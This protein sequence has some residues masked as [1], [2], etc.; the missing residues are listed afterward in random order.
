[1][2]DDVLIER[3]TG[4]GLECS[5][6]REN[7]KCEDL[8]E[9]QLVSQETF[10]R[11]E[12]ITH[13]KTLTKEIDHN[14]NKSGKFIHLGSVEEN[15]YN[16]KSDKK[17]FSQNSVVVKHKKVYAGKKV[18]KCNEC[19]KTFTHSSSLTVHQ[20]IHTGEKPYECKECGKN[21]G[22]SHQFTIRQSIHT[23]KKPYEC[24]EC[25]KAFY[26]SSYLVQH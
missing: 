13:N 25:G 6:F 15:I 12:V 21:F 11:K 8:F 24:G 1:M 23:G 22:S 2:Y 4:Y 7:W 9:R 16:Q 19:E 3:L 18:F 20:R 5:T 17:S 14:Y 26:S 10:I